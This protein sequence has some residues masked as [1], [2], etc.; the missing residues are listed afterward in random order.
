[1]YKSQHF[2]YIKLY[3]P[4]NKHS[5]LGTFFKLTTFLHFKFKEGKN[6]KHTQQQHS[7]RV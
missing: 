7:R 5:K 2:W 6:N 4:T 1:M 3:I